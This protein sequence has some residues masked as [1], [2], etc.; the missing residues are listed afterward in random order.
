M[1]HTLTASEF[2][3]AKRVLALGEFARAALAA[4]PA[5]AILA[6]FRRSFYVHFGPCALC[7]GPPGLGEGP[8]NILVPMAEQVEWPQLGLSAQQKVW[9][10]GTVVFLANRIRFDFSNA[11]VWKPPR[12]PRFS[13]D[14][15]RAGLS[16]VSSSA[17]RRSP[18]GL[19]AALVG[20]DRLPDWPVLPSNPLFQTARTPIR[21]IA[22]WL[23]RALARK[24]HRPP[25]SIQSLIGLGPGLT[26]SGDDF[27]CGLLVALNYFGFAD[28]ACK[29]SEAVLPIATRETN[30]ISCQHLRCAAGGHASSALFAALD[31]LLTCRRLEERL[32]AIDAIGHT[33]GWDSLAGAALVCAA[34]LDSGELIPRPWR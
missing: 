6:V 21:Q 3:V 33:S 8:V 26:P 16:L 25:P 13:F 28:A 4:Y 15:L 17:L 34:V 7:F 5:G 18:G 27:I 29:I 11:H 12:L 20:L 24:G 10:S 1:P 19:G 22:E 23:L 14:D 32:D 9:S 2:H 31:A 30:I